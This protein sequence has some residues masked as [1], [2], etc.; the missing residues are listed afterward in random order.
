MRTT[1]EQQLNS[2]LDY[3]RIERQVSPHTLKSY[4]RDLAQLKNYCL[5]SEIE[6]WKALEAQ[7]IRAHITQRHRS[8]LSGA[9]LQRELSAIRSLFNYLLKHDWTEHN[10]AKT[11][12][13]P[14]TP[15]KLPEVLDVDQLT[16]MLTV[17]PDSA[18]QHRDLAMWEL[19]YSSGLR[20]SEL[21]GLDLQDIDLEDQTVW[22]RSGK[23]G[24]DR[25][26][27]VGRVAIR[28]ITQWLQIRASLISI[29]QPALFISQRG[30]RISIRNVQ[31]RLEKWGRQQGLQEQVHPHMLRHSFATHMLESSGDIR[32]VQELLG[33]S[34]IS[35]TQIY[36]QLDFQHLANVYDQAHPRAK[37]NK[38][39][40]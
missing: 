12:R 36:T 7:H 16:S 6:S 35:T 28:A 13:A 18:L 26:V 5:T 15:R 38:K 27:P 29:N 8:G 11:V 14:K 30:N 21:A 25:I 22:V 37:R 24:K 39:A 4:Q 10:P 17:A 3:L 20:V 23:G 19:L 33:H 2:F 9:S 31:A 40:N 32:A 1:A 34:Q